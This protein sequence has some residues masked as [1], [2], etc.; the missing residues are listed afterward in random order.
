[1][2]PA[3]RE[4]TLGVHWVAK[5]YFN[6]EKLRQSLVLGSDRTGKEGQKFQ[7]SLKHKRPF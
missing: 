2:G 1:M 6:C 5:T 7:A 3:P 4:L